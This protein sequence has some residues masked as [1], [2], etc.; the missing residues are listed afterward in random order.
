MILTS[1]NSGQPGQQNQLTGVVSSRK[2]QWRMVFRRTRIPVAAVSENIEDGLT[3]GEVAEM[4]DGLTTEQAKAAL[5][6]AAHSLET[7]GTPR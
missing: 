4:F 5:E 2:G 6:F 1:V 3:V 7:P